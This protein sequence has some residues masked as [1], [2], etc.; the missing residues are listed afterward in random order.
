V[1]EDDRDGACSTHERED[2]CIK[3]IRFKPQGKNHSKDVGVNGKDDI[4]MYLRETGWVGVD[5]I[6]L[7]QD[8]DQWQAIVNT[9]MNLRVPKKE[10]NY[11]I[12]F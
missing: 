9:V 5:C 2:K 8:R 4:R 11:L 10:G 1:K 12:S 7:A 6:H 3:Y